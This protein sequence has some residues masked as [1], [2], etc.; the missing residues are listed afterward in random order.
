MIRVSG[1]VARSQKARRHFRRMPGIDGAT[2]QHSDPMRYGNLLR[3]AR[4]RN[5]VQQ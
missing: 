3:V 1:S 4:K 2:A 5:E